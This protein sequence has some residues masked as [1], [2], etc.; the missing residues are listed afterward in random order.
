MCVGGSMASK[1]VRS[2]GFK[3]FTDLK[4]LPVGHELVNSRDLGLW[5]LCWKPGWRN[6]EDTIRVVLDLIFI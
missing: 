2:P 1:A 6:E 5:S 4:L 3:M